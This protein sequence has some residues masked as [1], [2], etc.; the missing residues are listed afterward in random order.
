MS[1]RA[2]Q[3]KYTE[4]FRDSCCV[5]LQIRQHSDTFREMTSFIITRAS[6]RDLLSKQ[7]MEYYVHLATLY[8]DCRTRRLAKQVPDCI[9]P[10]EI[11]KTH[12]LLIYGD[13]NYINNVFYKNIRK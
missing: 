12:K 8:Y 1:N 9:Y 5:Q 3:L 4:H 13:T 7:F 2:V 6:K 10:K 11:M